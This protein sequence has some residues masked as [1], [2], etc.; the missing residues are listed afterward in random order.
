[1]EL[2][3]AGL[4]GGTRS[5]A[6][7]RKYRERGNSEIGV[8]ERILRQA[9]IKELVSLRRL[10]ALLCDQFENWHVR[11][12]TFEWSRRLCIS[13]RF[14][15]KRTRGR[16]A[17]GRYGRRDQVD[18]LIIPT[19]DTIDIGGPS[20]LAT[21]QNWLAPEFPLWAFKC[22]GR[23]GIYLL[24]HRLCIVTVEPRGTNSKVFD[25]L[26]ATGTLKGALTFVR[27]FY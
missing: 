1:M 26:K 10:R 23:V 22:P 21:T 2:W 20:S 15:R 27:N 25:T 3:L 17:R 19:P 5:Y 14:G 18:N 12:N 7:N 6:S 8:N 13:P 11:T 24:P 16:G 9:A 4:Y